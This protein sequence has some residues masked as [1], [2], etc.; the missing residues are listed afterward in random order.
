MNNTG[1]YIKT[2]LFVSFNFNVYIKFKLSG[3]SSGN[4]NSKG[5]G[6][7]FYLPVRNTILMHA[8]IKKLFFINF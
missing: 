5:L 6:R 7:S 3:R 8:A 1:L 2:Y 4:D